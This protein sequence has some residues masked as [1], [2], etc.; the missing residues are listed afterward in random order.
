MVTLMLQIYSFNINKHLSY[1]D[2]MV[3]PD[4][5]HSYLNTIINVVA[6]SHWNMENSPSFPYSNALLTKFKYIK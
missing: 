6:L 1:R 4:S 2:V 5:R 3:L